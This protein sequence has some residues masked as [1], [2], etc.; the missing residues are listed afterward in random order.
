MT[1][2]DVIQCEAIEG[3][4][5][6]VQWRRG[7]TQVTKHRRLWGHRGAPQIAQMRCQ[8]RTTKCRKIILRNSLSGIATHTFQR[9]LLQRV[10]AISQIDRQCT[11]WCE[12]MGAVCNT[13]GHASFTSGD[14]HSFAVQR[15]LFTSPKEEKNVVSRMAMRGGGRRKERQNEGGSAAARKV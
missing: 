15:L 1:L 3:L 9:V 5:E 10:N 2:D 7:V 11:L 4:G 12:S 13:G 8:E 6:A 14:P